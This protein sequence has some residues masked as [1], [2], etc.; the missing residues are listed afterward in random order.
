MASWREA[1]AVAA[2]LCLPAC[3]MTA[4]HTLPAGSAENARPS[5]RA[6]W[7]PAGPDGRAAQT[8]LEAAV[9]EDALLAWPGVPR[10][11]MQVSTEAVTWS[12]GS[13]GCPQPGQTYTQALV[14][15]WRL[16]VRAKGREAVY[17][18]S[19]R[20]QWLLCTGGTS[21]PGRPGE[22]TR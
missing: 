16:V 17:H 19:Q 13:L 4:G 18:A 14:A 22:V 5:P 10:A 9:R 1:I 2:A 8:A 12:D 6:G 21:A 3:A 15:D 20:G 7:V 11:Q